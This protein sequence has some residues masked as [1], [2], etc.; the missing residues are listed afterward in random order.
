M[1]LCVLRRWVTVSATLKVL[2]SA[3]THAHAALQVG[4]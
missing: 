2:I 4:C 1:L 3:G